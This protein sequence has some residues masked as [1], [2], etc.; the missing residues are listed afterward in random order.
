MSHR[1]PMTV[2]RIVYL[3][4]GGMAI[5]EAETGM[6]AETFKGDSNEFA[7]SGYS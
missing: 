4:Q 1:V 5:D 7:G 2:R 6:V 3:E